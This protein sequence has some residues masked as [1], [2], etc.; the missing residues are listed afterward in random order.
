M[1]SEQK[2]QQLSF[3]GAS[4]PSTYIPSPY[5]LLH[6]CREKGGTHI[7]SNLFDKLLNVCSSYPICITFPFFQLDVDTDGQQFVLMSF[8]KAIVNPDFIMKSIFKTKF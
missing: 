1:L 3:D 8:L 7:F 2:T 5:A 4:V 6:S